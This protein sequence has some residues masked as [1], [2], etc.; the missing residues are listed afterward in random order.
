MEE[1][2]KAESVGCVS[3]LKKEEAPIVKNVFTTW[4]TK[5]VRY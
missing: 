2:K 3:E 1:N 5:D 4:I